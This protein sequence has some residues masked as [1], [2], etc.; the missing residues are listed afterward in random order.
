MTDDRPL[1]GLRVFDATQ[2]IAGPHSTMLMAL[3]GAEV[4]KVEPLGGDW[5]RSVGKVW[6]DHCAH[7]AAFNRGKRSIALD[8][9]SDAGRAVA[10][11]LAFGADIVVEAFR[12]G[13]MDRFGLGYEEIKAQNP[14]TIY[15]SVT[16]YGQRGPNRDRKVSDAIMQAFSGMMY[17]NRD[18][19]G[20]PRRIG[21]I[22]IDV[23]TGLYAYQ[24]VASALLARFRFDRGAYIDCNLMQASAAFQSAK[25]LEHVLEDGAP[26]A[27]SAPIGT[28]PTAD[29]FI[30][31]SV[32]REEHY[33]ALCEALGR[34]DLITDPR[35]AKLAERLSRADELLDIVHV[36]FRKKTTA[37]WQALLSAAG[38]MNASIA[39]YGDFLADPHVAEVQAFAL[40][41]QDGMGEIPLVNIPGVPAAVPGS[42]EASAPHLGEHSRE[43]LAGAGYAA[44]EVDQMIAAG[45]VKAYA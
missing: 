41:N 25:I 40:G 33:V 36:E 15:C 22:A 23:L 10:Q 3:N 2:G 26:T 44:S 20:T 7:S 27:L 18:G 28:M 11:K 37:E 29:S 4:I 32:V 6:G 19:H 42:F 43:V 1:S 16:G 24:A 9:K 14:Q 31:V 21:M 5:G 39:D 12:P 8:L 34:P 17:M 38:I 45:A 30:N 35:F 13:V